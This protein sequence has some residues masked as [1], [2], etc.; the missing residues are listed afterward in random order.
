MAAADGAR[1]ANKDRDRPGEDS[2]APPREPCEGSSAKNDD[3]Q[4]QQAR[5]ER[6]DERAPPRRPWHRGP[7]QEEELR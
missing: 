5:N 6:A 4:R 3:R 2:D 7:C 1:T